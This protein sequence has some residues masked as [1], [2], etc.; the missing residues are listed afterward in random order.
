MYLDEYAADGLRF[1][2][3][4]Q[5]NGLHLRNVVGRLHDEFPDRYII[6]EH[7][8]DDPWIINEGRF[9][10]TW[11]ANAHHETQRALAGQD[12][13]RKIRNLLGWDG[14]A[15]AWNLVKYTLGSHDDIGDLE[16]GNAEAG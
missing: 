14:Y 10:A 16:N 9:S 13:V 4:T 5:I 1:D 3:T 2:V 8:P 12:P 7:L 6:A 15:H 11:C